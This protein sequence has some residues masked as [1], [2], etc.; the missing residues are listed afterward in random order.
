[1]EWKRE[2]KKEE[3]EWDEEWT[4]SDPFEWCEGKEMEENVISSVRENKRAREFERETTP[5]GAIPL[6]KTLENSKES[7]LFSANWR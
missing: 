7:S 3:E 1:M 6:L 2:K 5:S 4:Q